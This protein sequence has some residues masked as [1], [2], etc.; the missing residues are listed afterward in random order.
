MFLLGTADLKYVRGSGKFQSR[1]SIADI[2]EGEGLLWYLPAYKKDSTGKSFL[3]YQ[4]SKRG[5][6]MRGGTEIGVVIH[7]KI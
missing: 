1:G 4:E 3:C 5:I 7:G 2:A 6:G